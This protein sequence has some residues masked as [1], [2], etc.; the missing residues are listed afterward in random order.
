M[1]P[2]SPRRGVLAAVGFSA[3]LG[4]AGTGVLAAV[5]DT[6]RPLIPR[7]PVAE[8]TVPEPVPAPV[9]WA[10]STTTMPAPTTTTTV[11]SR[12][13]VKARRHAQA[14]A[15]TTTTTTPPTTTA[16]LVP[17]VE[18][19]HEPI[20]ISVPNVP[21]TPRVRRLVFFGHSY[22]AAAGATDEAH[23][24]ASLVGASTCLPVVNFAVGGDVSDQTRQR[25]EARLANLAEGDLVVVQS[26][27]NDVRRYGDDPARL[28]RYRQNLAAI[29]AMVGPDRLVIVGGVPIAGWDAYAPFDQG[30]P[31]VLAAYNAAAQAV[32]PS[33]VEV[34][35]WDVAAHVHE[36]L[37][38][39]NDAGHRAIADV[40]ARGLDGVSAC[41]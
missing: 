10:T 30:T 25:V 13:A 5:L 24:W 31:A 40:V 28:E 36:D 12:S 26:G 39:P 11:P 9:V 19:P 15:P 4:L 7:R 17:V 29:A 34:T 3:A 23:G 22:V 32:T 37:V 27:I 14:L 33:F 1:K 20:T 41:A 2:A 16:R 38:H 18:E 21:S 6:E 35:G 8:V